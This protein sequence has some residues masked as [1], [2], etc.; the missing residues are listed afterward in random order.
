MLT[1]PDRLDADMRKP[2]KSPPRRRQPA[3]RRA[4][5]TVEAILDAVIRLLRRGSVSAITTNNIAETAGVSIGSVYQY[6]PN[7]QAIFI[8]LHERHIQ[9]VDHVLRRKIGQS[10]GKTLDHL[11]AS[12]LDGMI[13]VH[14]SD[15]ELTV[16]LDSEVP[17]RADRAREFSI[18]LH[19]PFRKALAP[20][21]ESSGGAM[22]LQVQAFLL[23]NMLE[24][25]GHA[26]VLRRPHA[27]SLRSAK[28]EA[29]NAIL[30]SLRS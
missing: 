21:V 12:L 1:F 3:Q 2:A 7:K 20:Y 5:E 18:R 28:M 22:K 13:E 11:V 10:E 23:G 16:L 8:A 17:H 30:A 25:L 14:V 19:E 6:F 9:Q 24:A 27:L 26:V 29:V 15:P 4:Q